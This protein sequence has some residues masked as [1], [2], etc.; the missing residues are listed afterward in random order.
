MYVCVCVCACVCVCVSV[1]TRVSVCM[2]ECGA[3]VRV[4]AYTHALLL[5][6]V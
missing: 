5:M 3:D 1:C 4:F 2:Y 6:R